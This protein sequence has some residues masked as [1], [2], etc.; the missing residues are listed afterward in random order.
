MGK[1][2]VPAFVVLAAL[3]IFTANT[4]AQAGTCAINPEVAFADG[5]AQ[6]FSGSACSAS[7]LG[8]GP[9]GTAVSGV[10]NAVNDGTIGVIETATGTAASGSLRSGNWSRQ[11]DRRGAA[12]R[13]IHE[14]PSDS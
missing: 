4:R 7:V 9:L 12:T 2:N 3:A 10:V 1:I 8:L 14:F 13:R 6:T 11:C 5:Q